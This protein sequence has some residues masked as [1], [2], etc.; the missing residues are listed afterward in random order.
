MTFQI[1]III[2]TMFVQLLGATGRHPP[3]KSFIGG[4]LFPLKRIDLLSGGS[5]KV[6][7]QN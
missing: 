4:F 3:R 2:T 5:G 1:S 7:S 6:I